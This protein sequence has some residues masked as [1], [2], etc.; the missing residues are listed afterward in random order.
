MFDLVLFCNGAA[1]GVNKDAQFLGACLVVSE[2]WAEES[3]VVAFE[4]VALSSE[5]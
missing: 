2:G 1:L 4:G 5:L 3:V